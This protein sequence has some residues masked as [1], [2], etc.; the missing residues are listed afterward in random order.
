[1]FPVTVDCWL[2]M[3][4]E[5]GILAYSFTQNYF[6]FG[7]FV[8]FLATVHLWFSHNISIGWNRLCPWLGNIRFI[9]PYYSWVELLVSLGL[10]FFCMIYSSQTDA[11]YIYSG[12]CPVN[13]SKPP[14]TRYNKTG[15]NHDTTTFVFH[16]WDRI[17]LLD[18]SVFSFPNIKFQT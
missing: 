17:L 13:E 5:D 14:W 18:F 4:F 8:G 6:N 10:M 15:L 11:H 1:M 12:I 2:H 16:N 9:L 3:G 7:M